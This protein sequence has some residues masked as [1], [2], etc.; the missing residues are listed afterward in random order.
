V[1]RPEENNHLEDVRVQVRI[2]LKWIL[3]KFY[4][5]KLKG[6]ICITIEGKWLVLIDAVMNI[7]VP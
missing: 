7:L 4:G 6:F 2:I 5:N 1:E 3:K